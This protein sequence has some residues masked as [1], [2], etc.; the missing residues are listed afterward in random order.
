[1]EIIDLRAPEFIWAWE[2]LKDQINY[3][4]AFLPILPAQVCARKKRPGFSILRKVRFAASLFS[5]PPR[6]ERPTSHRCYSALLWA[7]RSCQLL[8]RTF[9]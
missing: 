9:S 4:K 7:D 2:L 3:E 1:M 8:W 6:R 5:E